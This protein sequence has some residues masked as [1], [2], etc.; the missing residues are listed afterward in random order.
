M[1]TPTP[2]L[3]LQIYSEESIIY[4]ATRMNHTTRKQKRVITIRYT[5]RK[6][7]KVQ[8]R[9]RIIQLSEIQVNTEETG[10]NR[11]GTKLYTQWGQM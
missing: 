3:Q 5:G 1:A 8:L 6:Q 4:T 2:I 7:C 10:Q 11:V 9:V